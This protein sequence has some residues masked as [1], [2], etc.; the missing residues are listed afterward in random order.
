MSQQQQAQGIPRVASGGGSGGAAG[1]DR[2]AQ[3]ND[4]VAKQKA[5]KQ[6]APLIR[7][8]THTDGKRWHSGRR[9]QAAAPKGNAVLNLRVVM[10]FH[11]AVVFRCC[12][13]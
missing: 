2:T 8:V 10:S 3:I 9:S 11:L 13:C 12:C 4:Y 5:A 6:N 1:L 7:K